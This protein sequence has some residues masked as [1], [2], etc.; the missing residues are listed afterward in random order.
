MREGVISG[1]LL[2]PRDEACIFLIQRAEEGQ[3][4]AADAVQDKARKQH[5]PVL[6]VL[7]RV[8]LRNERYCYAAHGRPPVTMQATDMVV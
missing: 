2:G 5:A 8:E 6:W 4:R 3:E 7:L 1:Y